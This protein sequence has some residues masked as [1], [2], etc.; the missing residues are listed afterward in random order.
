MSSSARRRRDGA[1]PRARETHGSAK[2]RQAVARIPSSGPLLAI[3]RSLRAPEFFARA[4]RCQKRNCDPAS[5]LPESLRSSDDAR[6]PG[7]IL[8]VR[9]GGG[10]RPEGRNEESAVLSRTEVGGARDERCRFALLVAMMVSRRHEGQR[11][12]VAASPQ[13]WEALRTRTM[14]DRSSPRAIRP[15]KSGRVGSSRTL[16]AA[17]QRGAGCDPVYRHRG[18]LETL[19]RADRRDW[20]LR[21]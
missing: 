2:T 1:E 11:C 8:F 19:T 21:F 16:C 3:V 18:G 20:T 13:A 9:F 12:R 17:H 4:R 14:K 5:K 10:S 6:R 15:S 7:R